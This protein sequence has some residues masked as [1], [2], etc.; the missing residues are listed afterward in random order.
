MQMDETEEIY[1]LNMS[2]VKFYKLIGILFYLDTL[3]GK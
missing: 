3:I 2:L 1:G